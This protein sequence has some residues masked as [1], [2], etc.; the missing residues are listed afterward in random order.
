VVV[1]RQ[2]L[3]TLH[4]RTKKYTWKSFGRTVLSVRFFYTMHGFAGSLIAHMT[5]SAFHLLV[6]I[7][8]L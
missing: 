4:L 5:L 8:S 7:I 2:N 6:M 3:R 1:E